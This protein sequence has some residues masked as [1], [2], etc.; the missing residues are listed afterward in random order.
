MGGHLG[1]GA[2]YIPSS[3]LS[4]AESAQGKRFADQCS[5][6][7]EARVGRCYLNE[8]ITFDLPAFGTFL[9][10]SLTQFMNVFAPSS[11]AGKPC[12]QSYEVFRFLSPRPGLRP[13]CP[14]N[15]LLSLARRSVSS[16]AHDRILVTAGDGTYRQG[17][18]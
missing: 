3:S 12:A 4:D 10:K 9:L 16:S 2:V 17:T 11:C 15:G 18:E 14:R 1:R 5:I 8:P 13:R 6:I 7:E